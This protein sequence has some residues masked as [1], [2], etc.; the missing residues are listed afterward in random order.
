[1]NGVITSIMTNIDDQGLAIVGDIYR[2]LGAEA[3]NLFTLMLT[4]YVIWWGY[5]IL[6][7]RESITPIDAAYRLGRACL[8]YWFATSWDTFSITI[9]ELVQAIPDRVGALIM[10]AMSTHTGSTVKDV[11]AIPGLFDQLYEK[12][13]VIVAQIYTGSMFDFLGALLAALVLVVV[14]LFSGIAVAAIL[15][16][17]VMLFIVLALA[18]VWII[19]A[20]YQWSSR[21]WDGFITLAGNLIIQQILIYAFLGF[22]S[23]MITSSLNLATSGGEDMSGKISYILPLVLITLVGIYVLIQIPMLAST[24][25]GSMSANTIGAWGGGIMRSLRGGGN[26]ARMGGR[27]AMGAGRAAVSFGRQSTAGR[28]QLGADIARRSAARS[29]IANNVRSN[30]RPL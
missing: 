6:A 30:S 29:M 23:G 5:G 15:A 25:S 13:Q 4:V 7:G 17:K 19:L 12:G 18:P 26:A 27:G 28:Q 8:I 10:N 1:M 3:E 2:K 9:Y 11:H 24:L 22:Y 21:Y 20:L 16:A 14:M